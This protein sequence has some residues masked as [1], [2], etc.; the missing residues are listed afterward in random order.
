MK[1]QQIRSA[2]DWILSQL[3]REVVMATPLGLGKPNQLVNEITSTYLELVGAF[4]QRFRWRCPKRRAI[5]S[6]AF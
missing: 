1:F 5:C 2:A 3:G 4:S 6:A